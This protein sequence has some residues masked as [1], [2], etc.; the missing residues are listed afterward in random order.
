MQGEK[1][2][3][4]CPSL[5]CKIDYKDKY[6]FFGPPDIPQSGLIWSEVD[7]RLHDDITH[8]DLGPKKKEFVEQYTMNMYCDVNDIVEKNGQEL[9]YCHKAN[10][11]GSIANKFDNSKFWGG[12]PSTGMYDAKNETLK[13]SGNFTSP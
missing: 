1:Y 11:Q 4:I 6:T 5:Q 8:A 3:E 13:I 12:L 10:L 9:Y 2:K 7:F